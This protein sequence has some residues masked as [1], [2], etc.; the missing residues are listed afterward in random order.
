MQQLPQKELNDRDSLRNLDGIYVDVT[1]A[2][3][4]SPPPRGLAA[5]QLKGNVERQLERGK[6]QLLEMGHFRT[7]D[8]HVEVVVTASDAQNRMV[9]L[10]VELNFVQICFM[11][12][13]PTVTFN[14]ART[15]HAPAAV[16]LVPVAQLADSV[17]R[18]I[19]R[20][21]DHFVAEYNRVNP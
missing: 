5:D 16:S 1:V 12:R 17:R 3:I 13:D 21:V 20:Q 11:R 14:R 10:L 15:W 19:T 18:E 2:G 7:G 8:P 9:A 6:V 4:P